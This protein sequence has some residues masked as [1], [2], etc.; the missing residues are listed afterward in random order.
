MADDPPALVLYHE[1][2]ELPEGGLGRRPVLLTPT[3]EIRFRMPPGWH[4]ELTSTNQSIL[5]LQPDLM[6]GIM[7][8]LWPDP[9]ANES[10]GPSSSW[11]ERMEERLEQGQLVSQFK[12]FSATGPGVGFDIEQRVSPSIRAAFRVA[13]VPFEGG[14][15]DFE[16]RTDADRATNYHRV[17][18]HLVGSFS[19][20]P[21]TVPAV[22]ERTLRS[23]SRN[24]PATNDATN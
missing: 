14:M 11:R 4:M 15:A 8:R 9:P 21:R 13:L 19:A 5:F 16:L 1:E 7:M 12:T 20:E 10:N 24:A 22:P 3:H 23:P 18:R 6:A 17:F 2:I